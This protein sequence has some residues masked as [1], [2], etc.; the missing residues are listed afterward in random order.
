MPRKSSLSVPRNTALCYVRKSWTKDETDAISPERQRSHI[1]A[2]CEANG[3]TPEW[4]E[5]TEGHKSGMH[6]KNRPGW[7]ALKARM[8]EPDVVAIVANDLARLHR[9]GWRIGDLL[10]F[11]DQKG[12]KLVLA[13]PARHIDFSSPHGRI[14]AQ[15]SAIF[16]EWYAADISARWKSSISYRKSKGITVGLP[17]FG[18]RRNKKTKF[19]EPT[20]EGVW[21]LPDGTW[22]AGKLTDVIPVEGAKWRGYFDLAKLILEMYSRRVAG[23][24]RITEMLQADGW[25]WRDRSGNPVSL[26]TEDIRRVT[27]NWPEYGGVV[28]GKKARD[29][30]PDDLDPE[31]IKL[32]PEHAVFDVDMLREVG[33]VQRER[34]VK[35]IN[36]G[37]PPTHPYPL[38]GIMYCAHCEEL[39]LRQNNP[40]LRSKLSGKSQRR[41]RH[42]P[43]IPCG[44]TNKS[45]LR[46]TLETDFIG[47]VKSLT[48]TPDTINHIKFLALSS[49][50]AK[51]EQELMQQ[52]ED[53]IARAKRRIEAARHLYTDGEMSKNEYLQRKMD[54]DREIAQWE[55]MDIDTE[56]QLAE[57]TMAIDV[58][59]KIN[60]LWDLSSD[61]DKQG[62]AKMLFERVVYDLDKMQI[63]DFSLKSWAE[64]FFTIL[65]TVEE[66]EVRE[67]LEGNIVVP[68][69]LEPV[70]S[71]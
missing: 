52:R 24:T 70:S 29:R 17:P 20:D 63:V 47:L 2:V 18:T 7:L 10:D 28:I 32:I 4:Y 42:M 71:P 38:A 51:D 68:T 6:E 5:D 44:C 50:K 19:L 39:A 25:A 1:Q 9:K 58:V 3:W 15:L 64:Q 21:L 62:L 59:G 14:F 57:L 56:R 30:S 22:V 35:K 31:T 11:V 12:V 66:Q 67:K 34:T 41:Y 53:G 45:V 37:R 55:M 13:D 61:E 36:S 43:G 60:R 40:K 26:E 33:R 46:E 69:G 49:G 54:A 16:D 48:V 8:G 27:N 23:R 65:V